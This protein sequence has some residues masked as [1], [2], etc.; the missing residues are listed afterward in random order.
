MR[1]RV[2]VRVPGGRGEGQR[3]FVRRSAERVT[4]CGLAL[5][6]FLRSQKASPQLVHAKASQR[7]ATW[8][9]VNHASLRRSAGSSIKCMA[10]LRVRAVSGPWRKHG[11]CNCEE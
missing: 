9:R 6:D 8:A 3:Q 2:R 7:P 1:V 10:A 11:F 4:R 5:L